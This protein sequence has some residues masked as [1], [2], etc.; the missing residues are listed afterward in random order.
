MGVIYTLYAYGLVKADCQVG[1]CK[2]VKYETLLRKTWKTTYYLFLH[3]KTQS[4]CLFRDKRSS[5][6]ELRQV[7]GGMGLALGLRAF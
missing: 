4:C 1:E 6:Y 7:K 5:F 3:L 2:I